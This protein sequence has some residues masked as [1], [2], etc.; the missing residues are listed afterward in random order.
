MTSTYTVQSHISMKV[1]I[2]LTHGRKVITT[3]N[4]LKEYKIGSIISYINKNNVLKMGG[5]LT[6]ITKEYFIYV[7]PL[8]DARYRVR[9]ANVKKMYVSD[10]YEAH[11]NDF[12][13]LAKAPQDYT[14]FPAEIMGIPIFYA[15]SN[16][17][18]NRFKSTIRYK[19]LIKWLEY[20]HPDDVPK[21]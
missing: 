7:T 17:E 18:L 5:F 2:F 1:Q 14:R 19:D 11:K 12:V 15:K 8:Y 21:T 9:F 20:F 6:K 3:Y 13:S 10:V 4:E 16:Y